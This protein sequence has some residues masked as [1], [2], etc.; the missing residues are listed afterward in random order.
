MAEII[1]AAIALAALIG[2]AFCSTMWIRM[3]AEN[4]ELRTLLDSKPISRREYAHLDFK[5]FDINTVSSSDYA[6]A[7]WQLAKIIAKR[8]TK[9]YEPHITEL[10]NKTVLTY[11]F[12]LTDNLED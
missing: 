3:E 10:H 9:H 5:V 6:S 1:F 7:K 11:D 4:K 8:I 12:D 2:C